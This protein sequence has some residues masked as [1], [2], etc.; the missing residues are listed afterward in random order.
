MSTDLVVIQPKSQYINAMTRGAQVLSRVYDSDKHT[1][2]VHKIRRNDRAYGKNTI[3]IDLSGCSYFCSYCWVNPRSLNGTIEDDKPMTPPQA[4]KKIIDKLERFGSNVV[5]V[6]G[7]ET[8][9]TAEW[10][11]DLIGCL[12][13]YFQKAYRT[14]RKLAKKGLIWIDSHGSDILDNASMV[15]DSL[16]RMR[17]RVRVFISLKAHPNDFEQVTSVNHIYANRAF[18]ALRLCWQNDIV[19]VPQM[20]DKLFKPEYMEWFYYKL[21]G[22]HPQAPLVLELDSLTVFGFKPWMNLHRMKKVDITLVKRDKAICAWLALLKKYYGEDYVTRLDFPYPE[23]GY[24]DVDSD[25]IVGVDYIDR[26][27]LSNFDL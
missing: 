24:F 19:A 15:V 4:A 6:T 10:T 13:G 14:N 27:I 8:F 5:Q 18:Q 12:Y 23:L 9:L 2:L 22:I 1:R 26:N 20:L 16:R 21:H 17:S 25:P 11:L 3:S 7:G